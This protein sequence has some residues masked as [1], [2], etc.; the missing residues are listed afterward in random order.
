MA[1]IN[2]SGLISEKDG[3]E[4]SSAN[5]I[6][7]I[8]FMKNSL[9]LYNLI[10]KEIGEIKTYLKIKIDSTLDKIHPA[11]YLRELAN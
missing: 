8:L 1:K 5:K 11:F 3:N 4:N 10:V 6:K 2:F 9:L 7:D